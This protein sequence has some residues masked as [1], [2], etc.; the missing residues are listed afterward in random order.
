MLLG[1]LVQ[2]GPTIIFISSDNLAGGLP[3]LR[4]PVNLV[5]SGPRHSISPITS[6]AHVACPLP[7]QWC[8][9]PKLTFLG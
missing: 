7:F 9:L 3:T 6:T 8:H 4:L 1:Y 2:V 5:R